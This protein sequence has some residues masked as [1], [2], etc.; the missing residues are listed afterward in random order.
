LPESPSMQLQ[1]VLARFAAL[2]GSHR[3]AGYTYWDE[4][5]KVEIV[6]SMITAIQRLAPAE[7]Y[8]VTTANDLVETT[9]DPS[10]V[11]PALLGI[12]R[13]L[14]TAHDSGYLRTMEDLIHADVFS[15]SVS[16]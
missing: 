16:V 4:A 7:S 12:I 3:N 10:D 11:I 13:S 2:R 1:Q 9:E 5:D 14:K 15:G 6:T 8:Y